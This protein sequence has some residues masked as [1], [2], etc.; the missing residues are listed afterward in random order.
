MS[1]MWFGDLDGVPLD[2]AKVRAT[3]APV[4]VD[5]PPAEAES[6]P[7]FNEVETD[8]NP[9]LGG[10]SPRQLASE[11][12]ATEKYPPSWADNAVRQ[13]DIVVNETIATKGTAAAREMAGQQGHGTM[14]YAVGIEP[15]IR[16]G[17]AFGNT[18]FAGNKADIQE[19]S[20]ETAGQRGIGT[21]PGT[22]REDIAGASAYGGA[23]ARDASAN[24]YSAFLGL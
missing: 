11:W 21:I 4:V 19:L 8:T 15:T 7:E 6:A 14:A 1:V 24:N 16:D 2:E 20:A 22:D 23:A 18:Y 12:H 10:L 17:A 9:M 5:A 3:T 13:H